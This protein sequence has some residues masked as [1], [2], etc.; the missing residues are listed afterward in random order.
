V[1][2]IRRWPAQTFARGFLPNRDELVERQRGA[3]RQHAGVD[4]LK[5]ELLA[6]LHFLEQPGIG[7][8]GCD[9]G[10][11]QAPDIWN[12]MSGPLVDRDLDAGLQVQADGQE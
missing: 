8:V 11:G 3:H 4:D 2:I 5:Q 12:P 10:V 9:A 7:H 1:D 6:C